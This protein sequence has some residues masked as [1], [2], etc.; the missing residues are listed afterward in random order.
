MSGGAAV[1]WH[2]GND[3]FPKTMIA[4]WMLVPALPIALAAAPGDVPATQAEAPA[5]AREA[6]ARRLGEEGPLRFRRLVV[7]ASQR[8]PGY[9][10]CG[11][12]S[13]RNGRTERFFVVIPGSFAVLERDGA[14][15]VSNYWRLNGC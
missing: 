8:M 5:I 15:L 9:A 10:V 6:V 14:G 13:L 1:A 4:S 7:R 2:H 11:E 12:V 3:V